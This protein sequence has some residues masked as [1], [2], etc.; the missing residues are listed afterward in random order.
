MGL[1]LGYRA[2]NAVAIPLGLL[3]L[4][5]GVW[6][7]FNSIGPS[8]SRSHNYYGIFAGIFLWG[9]LGEFIEH[10]EIISVASWN[11][12]PLLGLVTF[13]IAIIFMKRY[14]PDGLMFAIGTF[15]AVWLLHFVMINQYEFLGRS[16]WTTYPACGFFILLAVFFGFR[17]AKTR[18]LSGNMAYSL[19]MLL[20]AW[21]V[22]EYVWGWRLIPGPWALPG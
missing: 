10:L 1:A 7:V 12:L 18:G 13:M 14:L 9:F 19:A 6:F 22:L 21:T 5:L 3:L 2:G 4:G 20:S 17:M 16:H 8:E 15:N 11:M